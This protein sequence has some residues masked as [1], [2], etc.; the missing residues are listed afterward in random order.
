MVLSIKGS[1]DRKDAFHYK[2]RQN[3]QQKFYIQESSTFKSVDEM[4]KHYRDH[5][6][7]EMHPE[8]PILRGRNEER[9]EDE[10]EIDPSTIKRNKELGR[11]NF[12]EVGPLRTNL[13]EFKHQMRSGDLPTHLSL[14]RP[15]KPSSMSL[16]VLCS[17][18]PISQKFNS[19]DGWTDW[20]IDGRTNRRTDEWTHPL[21]EMRKHI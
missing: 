11:G 1:K 18:F 10:W 15:L 19:C 8:I 6:G 3:D 20:P 13:T 7:L 14:N 4:I 21:I 9:E 16:V 2:I 5:D 12:G 17:N